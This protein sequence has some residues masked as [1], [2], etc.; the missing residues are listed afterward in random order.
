MQVKQTM[1]LLVLLVVLL[2]IGLGFYAL[3]P[4]RVEAP[5]DVSDD[6][7]DDTQEMQ[8]THRFSDGTHT[9]GFS[10]TK[11]TPCHSVEYDAVVMESFPEQF[12]IDFRIVEDQALNVGCAQVIDTELVEVEFSGS[13]NATL[14]RMSIDGESISFE[15]IDDP[16]E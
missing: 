7:R 6:T 16:N 15:L 12:A 11:P 1:I 2:F 10:I 5:D 4:D 14:N 13:E 3:K 8:V 9:Y